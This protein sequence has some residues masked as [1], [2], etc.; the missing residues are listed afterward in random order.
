MKNN[1]CGKH[2]FHQP[3]YYGNQKK[4]YS[5]KCCIIIAFKAN[6]SAKIPVPKPCIRQWQVY[7]L[8]ITYTA[9]EK[10]RY[11]KEYHHAANIE[12]M[13]LANCTSQDKTKS[14]SEQ[15]GL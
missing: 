6:N 15:L 4:N 1:N 8:I 2:L 13:W 14:I 10:G 5:K 9:V 7:L 3:S 11:T 12:L